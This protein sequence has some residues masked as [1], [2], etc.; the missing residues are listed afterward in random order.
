MQSL[1]R[2]GADHGAISGRFQGALLALALGDALGAPHEGGA[3]ERLLWRAVGTTGGCMRWTDDTQMSLD[4]ADSLIA[5]GAP[6]SDDIARRFA[7]S[8]RWSR[9]YGPGA[10]KVLKRIARGQDW[11]QANRAVFPQ[12]SYGNGGA[13]RAPVLGLFLSEPGAGL[14]DA[15]VR[16]STITHA[17]PLAIEGALLVARATALA[18]HAPPPLALIA[19]LA[20]GC[21]LA[22][23]QDKL[24]IAQGWLEAGEAPSARTVAASLGN[25]IAASDSCVTAIY[26][27]LRLLGQSFLDMH[28]FVVA[29]KGD[30]DTIGAMAGAI[31]GAANG[32]DRLPAAPLRKLEQHDRL[33]A[34][35]A[36]LYRATPAGA[37][38]L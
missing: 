30:V 11:R 26:I 14:A 21:E 25:G 9:G 2:T 10:A 28:S 8:Y 1:P 16:V 36:A 24:G 17:H 3:L 22:P 4:V 5:L 33:M 27:A 32:V 37:G 23:Y 15:V 38:Y 18:L 19:A 35:A 6:D 31:W 34:A 20:Q 29:A 12:G 7:A 13:M